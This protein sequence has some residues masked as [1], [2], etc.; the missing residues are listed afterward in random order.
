MNPDL[1]AN[2]REIRERVRIAAERAN[3]DP[4]AITTIA[5]SKT[6][7]RELIDQAYGQ[8]FRVFGE[9]RVQEIRA[10]CET[11]FP[12]DVELHMIGPLQT[13]KIRQIAPLVDVLQT[14][15]RQ[16]LIDSLSSELEKQQSTLKVLL[17]VNIAGEVQKSGVAPQDASALLQSAIEAIGIEPV[18]L[19]TMAPYGADDA[20]LRHV[21][22]GLRDLRD[23]LQ[24]DHGLA[25]PSLSM[26]MS[27]DFE[28]A[29]AEGATHVRI[30]RAIF[31]TR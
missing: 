6:F 14:L 20:T 26:G 1:Q 2:A 16:R 10:K 30:G 31:G 15:D 12:D 5:V 25:L 27:D 3:R 4:D 29:I 13:N 7:D 9:S 21:F 19:M 11:P 8:G 23:Q 22:G 17:Q 24:Q 18:G 28:I